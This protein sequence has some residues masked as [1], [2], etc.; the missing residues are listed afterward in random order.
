M[1]TSKEEVLIKIVSQSQIKVC[2]HLLDVVLVDGL[3]SHEGHHAWGRFNC[4]L[5]RIELEYN[6]PVSKLGE[7]LIHEIL[8][9]IESSIDLDLD[10][11][12]IQV[13]ANSLNQL[14][15]GN[16]LLNKVDLAINL[17]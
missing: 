2:G 1:G 8:H 12:K 4:E 3:Y 9:A 13:L 7:T 5:Q 15:F 10:E 16:H 11:L 17:D 14:G 6:Q